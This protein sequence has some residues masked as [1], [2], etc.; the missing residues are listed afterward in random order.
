MIYIFLLIIFIFCCFILPFVY[1]K[2]Y[3]NDKSNLIYFKLKNLL[4][5]PERHSS[6]ISSEF[7][8]EGG[9]FLYTFKLPKE[10]ITKEELDFFRKDCQKRLTLFRITKNHLSNFTFEGFNFT[11]T[12]YLDNLV[13]TIP[14]GFCRD[15]ERIAR[16]INMP[17][18]EKLP[19]VVFKTL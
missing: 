19:H 13:F 4:L 15:Y 18:N 17:I 7:N 11:Y 9:Y 16:V 12:Y 14:H 8:E 5:F 1:Y 3:G 10:Y 6:L 2:V